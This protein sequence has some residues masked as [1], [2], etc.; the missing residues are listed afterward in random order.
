MLEQDQTTLNTT[1]TLVPPLNMSEEKHE[2]EGTNDDA[3]ILTY[4]MTEQEQRLQCKEEK[5]GIYMSTFSYK[6][7][8]SEFR[9]RHGHRFK[10]DGIPVPR[11]KEH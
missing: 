5:Y 7:D 6:G 8:D 11:V 9:L 4:N 2:K 1:D 10:C 3:E